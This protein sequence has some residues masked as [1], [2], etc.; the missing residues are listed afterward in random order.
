MPAQIAVAV[1]HDDAPGECDRDLEFQV[2]LDFIIDA[3]D[4][5][6]NG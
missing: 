6:R 2:A 3:L 1:T 4:R 5:L